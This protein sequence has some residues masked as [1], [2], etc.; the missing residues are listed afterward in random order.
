MRQ[1]LVMG[2]SIRARKV[3]PGGNTIVTSTGSICTLRLAAYLNR[4]WD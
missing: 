2:L 1:V 3:L 4:A